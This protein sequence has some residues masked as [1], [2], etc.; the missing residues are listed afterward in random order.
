MPD[1]QLVLHLLQGAEQRPVPLSV[2]VLPPQAPQEEPPRAAATPAPV[3]APKPAATAA[4]PA[5]APAASP[6]P[7]A[8]EKPKVPPGGSGIRLPDGTV[9]APPGLGPKRK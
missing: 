4:K 2:E 3:P 7:A 8:P 9:L 5:A 6:K 1:T